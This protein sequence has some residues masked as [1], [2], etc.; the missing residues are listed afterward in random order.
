MIKL[1]LVFRLETQPSL[2][3][4]FEFLN[5]IEF[6]PHFQK[7]LIHFYTTLFRKNKENKKPTL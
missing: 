1:C 4:C 2:I 7:T 5:F 6:P 3:H